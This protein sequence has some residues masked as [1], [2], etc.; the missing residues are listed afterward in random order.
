MTGL[1]QLSPG[2]C[3]H[4]TNFDGVGSREITIALTFSKAH[5]APLSHL[6]LYLRHHYLAFLLLLKL[7]Y[8]PV[9]HFLFTLR[10]VTTTRAGEACVDTNHALVQARVRPRLNRRRKELA[11]KPLR[12]QLDQDT[13]PLFE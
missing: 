8:N 13:K 10:P 9:L 3:G 1:K 7:L 6:Y 12:P 4:A 11:V 5:E 2:L